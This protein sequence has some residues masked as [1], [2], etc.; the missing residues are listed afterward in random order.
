[1]YLKLESGQ[2]SFA[3]NVYR[4]KNSLISGL[5]YNSQTPVFCVKY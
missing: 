4:R 3:R 5:D 1:M 2:I